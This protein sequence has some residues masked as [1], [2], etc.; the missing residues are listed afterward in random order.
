[1]IRSTLFY[2]KTSEHIEIINYTNFQSKMFYSFTIIEKK[3]E[4]L[5]NTK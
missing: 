5:K 2:L 4:E 1:M 3:K